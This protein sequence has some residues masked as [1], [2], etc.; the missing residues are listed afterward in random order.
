MAQRP[1]E[2]AAVVRR[3]GYELEFP[4]LFADRKW[5]LAVFPLPGAFLPSRRGAVVAAA[6]LAAVLLGLIAVT[7]HAI[8]R[9]RHRLPNRSLP[10]DTR[11]STL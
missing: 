11:G 6:G 2:A 7:L 10:E 4:V 3:A 5:A 1:K 9:M 8:S